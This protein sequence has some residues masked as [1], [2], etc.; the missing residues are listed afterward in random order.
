VQVFN[1]LT[2]LPQ[3][4]F[5][6][7]LVVLDQSPAMPDLEGV[8]KKVLG[9]LASADQPT[10]CTG[11]CS[12]G[13]TAGWPSSAWGRSMCPSPRLTWRTYWMSCGASFIST[14]CR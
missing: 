11:T 12:G 14:A 6:Q 8:S 2:A 4:Q 5:V 13:G 9:Y 1:S 10:R 3:K 7:A